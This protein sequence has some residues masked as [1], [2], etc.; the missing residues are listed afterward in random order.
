MKLEAN[1][2]L[3]KSWVVETEPTESPYP[4]KRTV[5]MNLDPTEYSRKEYDRKVERI[6]SGEDLL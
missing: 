6:K 1:K 3:G 5:Y 4:Y 2:R